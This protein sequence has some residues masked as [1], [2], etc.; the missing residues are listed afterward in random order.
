ML[1]DDDVLATALSWVAGGRRA[2]L[3]TVAATW[4][5][6][7]RPAGSRM[8]I[9]QSGTIAGSVTAGCVEAAVVHEAQAAMDDGRPR[10]LTY[11]VTEENAWSV[12]LT[13]GGTVRVLVT[14]LVDPEPSERLLA[15]VEARAAAALVTDTATGRQAVVETDGTVDG[16]LIL[17][18]AT[19]DEIVGRV[20]TDRTGLIEG[21][22]LFAH[23]HAPPR[24]LYI[25]GAVHI[26]QVLVEMARMTGYDTVVVD[27]RAA[28]ATEERFPETPLDRRWPSEAFAE[29]GLDAHTAVVSLTHD[30]KI[31]DPAL[32]A[33]L[34]SEAFY[35]GALGSRIN[36]EKRRARLAAAGVPAE[37]IARLH[38]PV[39]LAIG[40]AT[41]A[42]IALSI[43]AEITA[44]RRGK[45]A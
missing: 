32:E 8:A 14:P 42:E 31:D 20:L 11:G 30:D 9:D 17:D 34:R 37:R 6:S 40:A 43:M 12:G 25:V 18:T 5:S 41:P 15:L 16:P 33:A 22:R 36:Q 35:V 29:R 24:R 2:A 44:V 7:P 10:L 21:D 4:G 27:P 19:R 26:A 3:A 13:C 28:F 1:S 38:G 23:V 45:A 39:G